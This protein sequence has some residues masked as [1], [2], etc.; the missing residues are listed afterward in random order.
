MPGKILEIKV[1]V[2]DKI[3]RGQ[4]LLV[5]E[6]MKMQNDIPSP[7]EGTVTAINT[8]VGASVASGDV[9]VVLG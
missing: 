4:V 7:S 1:K 9:L 3:S 6:S 8:A 5:M 2:G